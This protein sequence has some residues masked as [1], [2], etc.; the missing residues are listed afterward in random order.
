MLDRDVLVSEGTHL[1]E[2]AVEHA[3]EAGRGLRLRIAA[4]DRRLLREAGLGLGTKLGRCGAGPF[5]ERSRKLLVEK[6]DREVVRAELRIAH[7]PRQLLRP[8][9][10]LL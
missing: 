5:D 3:A 4:G 1:V 8:R 9:D 7:A 10:C 2:S 6:C